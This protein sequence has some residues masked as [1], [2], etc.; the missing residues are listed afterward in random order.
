MDETNDS[1]PR[2][3][4]RR[5]EF[6]ASKSKNRTTENQISILPVRYGKSKSNSKMP[7]YG[8]P[9]S[10]AKRR[11]NRDAT[12][13]VGFRFQRPKIG[14]FGGAFSPD[15][16]RFQK[17]NS[18]PNRKPKCILNLAGTMAAPRARDHLERILQ[19]SDMCDRLIN[20]LYQTTTSTAQPGMIH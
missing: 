16:N 7:Y 1:N 18:N 9:N 8:I 12:S 15:Q 17:P 14:G 13:G 3:T 5:F 19:N 4:L 20:M 6:S 11:G 2:A 10:K